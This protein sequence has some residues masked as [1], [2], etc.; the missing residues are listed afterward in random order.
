[1]LGE[2]TSQ[3]VSFEMQKLLAAAVLISPYL[4]MLFMGEEYGE[5]NPFLYFVSHG[6]PQLV[7]AVRKGRKAEFAA[8]HAKGEAPDP[9]AEETFNASKLQWQLLD[10]EPHKTLFRYY[11]RL[12]L[13]RKHPALKSLNRKN[14]SV[15]CSE[16]DQTLM[17]Y[18]HENGH[19]IL[20]MMNFSKKSQEILIPPYTETWKKLISSSDMEWKGSKNSPE[21]IKGT[22]GI[23]IEPESVIIY[24]ND[25]SD[26]HL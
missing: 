6:D 19:H 8:F 21:T 14:L 25:K 22:S 10:Q 12:I 23:I 11:Q 1:M 5:T 24:Q 3:L 9:Q 26:F 20:S 4:P 2:R 17:L 13:L 18:R 7:E 15:E 16:E